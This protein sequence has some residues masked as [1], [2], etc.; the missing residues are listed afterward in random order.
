MRAFRSCFP[1]VTETDSIELLSNLRDSKRDGD[2]HSLADLVWQFRNSFCKVPRDRLYAFL[3]MADDDPISSLRA[4]YDRSLH[5]V[6]S[7]FV[8]YLGH[9]VIDS[10]TKEIQI[11]QRS[12]LMRHL[13]VRRA[14]KVQHISGMPCVV[15]KQ[16]DPYTY[17]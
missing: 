3:G 11:V 7:D 16:D 8:Q 15:F 17:H 13:F 14:V 6:Y 2:I 12:A 10:A 1:Y 4:A 9:S 5:D